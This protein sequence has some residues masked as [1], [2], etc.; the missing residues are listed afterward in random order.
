MKEII[1]DQ[2]VSFYSAVGYTLAVLRVVGIL[3]EV[4][5]PVFPAKSLRLFLMLLPLEMILSLI[6]ESGLL[7]LLLLEIEL[8]SFMATDL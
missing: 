8:Y 2:I 3:G 7:V 1:N 6:I 5:D 4:S